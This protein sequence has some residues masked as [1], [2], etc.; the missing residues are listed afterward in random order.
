MHLALVVDKSE[1]YL[2]FQK[3]MILNDWSI[4]KKDVEKFDNV[5][6]SGFD[7]LFDESPTAIVSMLDLQTLKK[8]ID[9]LTKADDDTLQEKFDNGVI[10]LTN[11]P[12]NS[13]K[14]LETFIKDKGGLLIVPPTAKEQSLSAKIVGSMGLSRDVRDFV[15]DYVGDDYPQLISLARSI[16]SA[17]AEKRKRI[18]VDDVIIRFPQD[19][20]S[21]SIWGIEKYLSSGNAEKAIEYL[22]RTLKNTPPLLALGAIK[23][24]YVLAYRVGAILDNDS[25][26]TLPKI[27][28]TLNVANN[29]PLK[30]AFDMAKST[31]F[32]NLGKI[33]YRIM[34]T[35]SN[36]KGGLN[37]N[38]SVLLDLLVVDICNSMKK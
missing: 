30:L 16:S 20:G 13:T 17:S 24:K 21:V 31:N 32:E 35:D 3:D 2:E 7:N 18:T 5:K 22:H 19:K 38:S 33:F 37:V 10:F 25:T 23:S 27:A 34:E 6:D 15:L 26:M 1:A 29:Y 4:D 14:K 12:R 9:F 36:M 28:E 11:Q 8:N